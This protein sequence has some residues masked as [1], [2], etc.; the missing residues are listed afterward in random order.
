MPNLSSVVCTPVPAETGPDVPA[1]SGN[2]P[3]TDDWRRVAEHLAATLESL[4][5]GF[6]TIDRDWRFTY[7]N[8]AAERLM[9]RPRGELLGRRITDEFSEEGAAA[10]YAHYRRAQREGIAVEAQEYYA[11]MDVW[12][13]LK[14][15]PS[16]QGLAVS[17]RNV[18][19][20][21][22][23]ERELLRVNAELE[24]RVSRRTAELELANRE[25]EAFS[26]S[27]AHDLRAP[28]A[29]ISGFSETLERTAGASLDERSLHYLSRIRRGV[30]HM[31]DLADGLLA[32]ASLSRGSLRRMPVDLAALA[33]TVNVLCRERAPQRRV[34]LHVAKSL[35]ATGDPR[36]LAQVMDNLIGNAWK[37]TAGCEHARIEVGSMAGPDARVTYYVRDNGAGFDMQYAAKLFEPFQRLHSQDEFE[38]T[39]IG[40]AIVHKVVTRHGGRIWAESAPCEGA[41]FYFTL[42]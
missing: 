12:L 11:P 24:S 41:C 15:Y 28:L 37:F 29:A 18:T 21:V 20:R 1:P 35:P 6:F 32:L 9:R 30:V 19:D 22:L 7:V 34:D 38:G 5:D 8:A 10:F 4:T 26:Y 23:A 31:S 17:F 36:L 40:L 3:A 33:R 13:Q 16:A 42:E 27:I 39:G 25:L 14:A 2:A